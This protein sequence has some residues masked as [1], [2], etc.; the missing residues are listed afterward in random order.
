MIVLSMKNTVRI[1]FYFE[2]Y[3]ILTITGSANMYQAFHLE[4]SPMY[5]FLNLK[6]MY[7]M[8]GAVYPC[9]YVTDCNKW[10][11]I[12]TEFEN[13]YILLIYNIRF[14]LTF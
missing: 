6:F 5:V 3:V 7:Q 4:R 10:L 13:S 14:K 2:I 12:C 8:A 9:Q 11:K 1:N